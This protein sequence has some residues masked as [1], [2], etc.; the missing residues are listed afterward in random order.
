MSEYEYYDYLATLTSLAGDNA[1]NFITVFFAYVACAYIAGKKITVL[2]CT[3]LTIAYWLFSLLT[4]S[5]VLS[6]LS[7][8][9]EVGVE[10]KAHNYDDIE[11]MKVYIYLGPLS[12]ISAWFM[13][14][15]YMVSQNLNRES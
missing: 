8:I 5:G 3:G 13:S 2:Q 12:L 14:V 9:Y 4:I 1:M 6:T 10:Y 15:V 11:G 7:S